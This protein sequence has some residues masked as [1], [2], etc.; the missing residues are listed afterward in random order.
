MTECTEYTQNIRIAFVR[1]WIN[2]EG[3]GPTL[4]KCYTNVL[5]LLGDTALWFNFVN[6]KKTI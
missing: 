3:V 1:C 6:I 4:Y 2:V 5:C